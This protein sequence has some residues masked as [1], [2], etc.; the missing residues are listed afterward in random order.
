VN[1]C[2]CPLIPKLAIAVQPAAL[3]LAVGAIGRP[4][5]AIAPRTT[6]RPNAVIKIVGSANAAANVPRPKRNRLQLTLLNRARASAQRPQTPIFRKDRVIDPAVVLSSYSRTISPSSG[7]AAPCA[8]RLCAAC[9]TARHAIDNGDVRAWLKG[10][11][12]STPLNG[13]SFGIFFALPKA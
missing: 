8:V 3:P 7:F 4:T 9:S 13:M 6:A 1:S 12:H 10:S 11:A 2:S 5:N